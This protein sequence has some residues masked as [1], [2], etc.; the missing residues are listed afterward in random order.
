MIASEYAQALFELA[1][2]EKKMD[3]IYEQ[4][5]AYK[6]AVYDNIE[7][8]KMMDS[9]ALSKKTKKTI[10]DKTSAGMNETFIHFLY[11]LVDNKRMNQII[12]IY[13]EF[14][15]MVQNK[16]KVL[17]VEVFSAQVLDRE[18]LKLISKKLQERYAGKQIKIKNYIEPSLIGGIQVVCDG[19]SI[20][21]S[22][23]NKLNQLKA[24]L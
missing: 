16:N 1:N 14:K 3:V 10:I 17:K 13:Y 24:Q 12:S 18:S 21:M 22:L 15:R 23:K 7:F 8:I 11:V 20:D 4:F 5:R 9:P 2:K 19:E 6:R